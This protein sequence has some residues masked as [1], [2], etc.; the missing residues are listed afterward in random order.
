MLYD[1]TIDKLS[2]QAI[3]LNRILLFDTNILI[4]ILVFHKLACCFTYIVFI[5][6]MKYTYLITNASEIIIVAT[7]FFTI[8]ITQIRITETDDKS[9]ILFFL[10]IDFARTKFS[11][12]F[13]YILVFMNHLLNL[14]YDC[15]KQ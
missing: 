11:K 3:L 4:L 2:C 6:K 9:K 13:L 10:V 12:Y 15:E 7:M 1:I 8:K 14:S 5:K